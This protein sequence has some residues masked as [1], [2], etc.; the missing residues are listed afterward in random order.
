MN[1]EVTTSQ[2]NVVMQWLTRPPVV[3]PLV[4][5]AHIV[6]LVYT[7]VRAMQLG[8]A[9]TWYWIQPLWLL[10]YSVCWLGACSLRKW[11]VYTYVLLTVINSV[12]HI[13]IKDIYWKDALTSN[14]FLVDMLFSFFLMIYIKRF[15]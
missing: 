9:A 2:P 14:L 11:G 13:A 1:K 5:L 4:A 12:A 3:L 10:L 6:A 8:S 15:R 7:M